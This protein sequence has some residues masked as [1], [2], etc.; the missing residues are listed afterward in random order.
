MKFILLVEGHTE[1]NSIADFLK[2]WLDLR[3]GTLI[4]IAIDRFDGWS[5]FW[6]KAPKKAQ[7]YLDGPDG[8]DILAVIGL[9]D[10][11]GPRYP[12]AKTDPEARYQWGMDEI[13]RQVDR[14]KFRMF[15]AVHEFE[16]WIL[17][18]PELLPFHPP[19]P[20]LERMRDPEK[21]NFDEPP[22]RLLNWLYRANYREPYKKIVHGRQL[23][24]KLDPNEAYKKCPHLKSMLDEMLSLA[25]QVGF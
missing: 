24:K 17:T 20:G 13:E 10:L 12:S 15:F 11:Y 18:Q 2:R 5:D 9:L 21:I 3:L 14:E 6:R 16:A 19:N 8:K 25:Q 23:F 4:G 22:S 1:K 7:K